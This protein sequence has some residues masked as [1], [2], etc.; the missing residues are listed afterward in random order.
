MDQAARMRVGRGRGR[1]AWWPARRGRYSRSIGRDPEA[2]LQHHSRASVPLWHV[3][4]TT[5]PEF[6]RQLPTFVLFAATSV[7]QTQQPALTLGEQGDSGHTLSSHAQFTEHTS[8]LAAASLDVASAGAEGSPL[9]QPTASTIRR[10]AMRIPRWCATE[11][12]RST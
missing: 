3:V 11:T 2:T 8:L 4:L 9:P 5:A 7:G 12:S 10:G 6:I 1:V